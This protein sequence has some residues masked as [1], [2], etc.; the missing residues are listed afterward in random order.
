MF[1]GD[2]GSFHGSSIHKEIKRTLQRMVMSHKVYGSS[3]GDSGQFR[4]EL[5]SFW[6][7]EASS[8]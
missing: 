3:P 8:I 7:E 2:S 6:V 4:D 5:W 1:L